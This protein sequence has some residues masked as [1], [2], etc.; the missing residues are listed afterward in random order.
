MVHEPLRRMPR[1]GDLV[2]GSPDDA[3]QSLRT[4]VISPRAVQLYVN[5]LG[6]QGH[7]PNT[8]RRIYCVLNQLVRLAV[9]RRYIAVNPCDAVKLP[10]KSGRKREISITPLT[11]EEV[12]ALVAAIDRQYR[13]PVLLDAYLGPRAGELWAL[14]RDDVDLLRGTL[15]IGEALSEVTRAAA[16][17]VSDAERL[18]DSLI[19]KGTKTDQTRTLRLP[20]FLKAE[21]AD[22]LAQP[23]GGDDPRAFIFTTE[24]GSPVRHGNFYKRV[25]R[26]A[27]RAASRRRCSSA[28]ASTTS[29]THAPC[30]RSRRARTR[31]R[32]SSSSA[33]RT[34]R[35]R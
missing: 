2:R 30:S 28:S 6:D 29:A 5:D 33:T 34:S 1:H 22:H 26:P 14:R 20:A 8:I 18:T 21:L 17:D 35:R 16:K 12:R 32:S 25:Y 9:E 31:C 24:D 23:L 4:V 15:R 3:R 13:L 7:A 11:H 27:V 10:K 19:V